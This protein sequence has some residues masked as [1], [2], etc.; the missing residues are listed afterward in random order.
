MKQAGIRSRGGIK[1]PKAPRR[2]TGQKQPSQH[3][4]P[5][6]LASPAHP[7]PVQGQA[8]DPATQT[9]M[10]SRLGRPF[11]DV[12]VHTGPEAARSAQA[13]N[14]HAF[15]VGSHIVFDSGQY[16]PWS[17]EGQ[18]LLAH[19]LAHVAQP[20]VPGQ[21]ISQRGDAGERE[22]D[23]AASAVSAGRPATIGKAA[24]AAIQRQEKTR[25]FP[26]IMTG[27]VA[28]P[29]SDAL[30]ENAGPLLA[31]ALG[32]ATLD[33]FDTGKAVLKRE[34]E[35]QI[36]S[37]VRN[38]EI[39]LRKYSTSTLD[40]TGFADTVG[41]EA[42]NVTL[43]QQRADAVKQALIERG[44][45]EGIINAT[46]RGEGG[47]QAVPTKNEVPSAANRRVVIRFRP[48]KSRPGILGG[49]LTPP[50]LTPDKG[51]DIDITKIPPVDVCRPPFRCP[52]PN[53]ISPDIYKPIP[54]LK[55][56]GKKS[57]IDVIGEKIIDPVVDSVLGG[58]SK[59]TRDFVKEK[60]R[61][62]VETGSAKAARAAAEAAGV[63]DSGALDAIEKATEAAIKE[64][65]E[66]KQ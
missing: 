11:D 30:I 44:I 9:L 55:G 7:L 1:V 47:P 37:V 6:S 64:K 53:D 10:E 48:G 21:A 2:S 35:R 29:S 66:R 24:G 58:F 65:G 25:D 32:S 39:L 15:S 49:T 22:A 57:L 40:V 52:G 54:P 18:H 62:A 38:V 50:D 16:R 61:S 33:N 63:V 8:L 59:D 17:R 36:T 19:E 46:S 23:Q 51:T 41:E 5:R 3:D 43:G 13:L 56:S 27:K 28:P 60:A 34:H 26:N 45:S 12:Q 31:S 42:K 14:A 20:V 4:A